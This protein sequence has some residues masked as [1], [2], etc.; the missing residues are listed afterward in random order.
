MA[1]ERV[2]RRRKVYYK[3][4]FDS[5]GHFLGRSKVTPGS[6]LA[7]WGAL[8]VLLAGLAFAVIVF[9][10]GSATSRTSHPTSIVP[11]IELPL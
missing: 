5:D 6:R 7:K 10:C 11:K 3:Y 9:G 1:T 2:L 4:S 8:I